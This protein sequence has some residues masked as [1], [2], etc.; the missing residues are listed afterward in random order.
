MCLALPF[1]FQDLRG[2]VLARS[3]GWRRFYSGLVLTPHPFPVRF[4]EVLI[5][6]SD[7][8]SKLSRTG[9]TLKEPR[10]GKDAALDQLSV[11]KG[12]I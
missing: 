11:R 9:A 6:M 4:G 8:N 7:T 3:W 1:W 10:R 12:R 5:K 2:K